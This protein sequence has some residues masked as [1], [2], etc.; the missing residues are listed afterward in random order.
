M[1]IIPV[2]TPLAGTI[3]CREEGCLNVPERCAPVRRWRRIHYRGLDGVLFPDPLL[4]DPPEAQAASS[5][6]SLTSSI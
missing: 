6:A 1:L 4:E 3:D 5:A 2:V